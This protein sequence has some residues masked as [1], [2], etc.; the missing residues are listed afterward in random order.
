[1]STKATELAGQYLLLAVSGHFSHA[2]GGYVMKP[3]LLLPVVIYLSLQIS[4]AAAS[5]GI[6][7]RCT[8]MR[9]KVGCTCAVQN[10]GNVA[11]YCLT[12]LA[13]R[14]G[15]IQGAALKYPYSAC[16]VMGASNSSN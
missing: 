12:D 16:I 15:A 14:L 4:L 10:R 11:P 7:P 9:D 6:D 3:F 13:N 5:A 2:Y 1:M 8:E